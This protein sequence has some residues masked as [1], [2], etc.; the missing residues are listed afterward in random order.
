[1]KRAG[2][3]IRVSHLKEDG[4][5]PD[6]QLEKAQ[7]QADL[8]DLEIVKVYPDLDISGRSVDKRTGFKSM[9]DDVKAGKLD[10][11]LVYRLDRFARNVK[12]FHAYMDLLDQNNCSLV[13]ISQN[14]DTSS[15]TGRLLRNIL[16]DFA[17][18][19]SEMISERVRDNMIQNARRGSWNGGKVSFGYEWDDSKKIL[20]P[21]DNA[22]WVVFMFEEYAKGVGANRIR[23]QL[24]INNITSPTGEEWW[25][26]TSIR[27]ILKNPIY[28]GYIE[29]A[30]ESHVGQHEPI[31]TKVLYER[32]QKILKDN[33]EMSPRTRSSQHLLSGLLICPFCGKHLSVRYNGKKRVRRYVC[34]T[35]SNIGVHACECMIIDADSLEH[36][37]TQL[38]LSLG[39][40]KIVFEEARKAIHEAAASS[41]NDIA[42]SE[43]KQKQVQ[44]KRIQQAMKDLFHDFYV[45]KE[46]SKE[47]FTMINEGLLNEE[48]ELKSYLDR[49]NQAMTIRK[50]NE[51]NLLLII[52]QLS[53]LKYH[54]P[55]FNDSEK[56]LSL[57]NFIK[58]IIPYENYVQV[59]L[60]FSKMK[61][62]PALQSE[63]TMIF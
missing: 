24:K 10:C 23:N 9:M 8:M 57:R 35:R 31:I 20:I 43:I 39:D 42:P 44:L 38:I 18:F 61:I 19:E 3:Y 36:A 34:Y 53:S 60:F 21:N 12:D 16:I 49:V 27:N 50:T 48:K 28:L 5:S 59:D 2:V 37:I 56:R 7:L 17:Q 13:S 52:D 29:Y 33:A 14:L 63:T 46:I 26:T 51:D 41:I 47:Q 25:A 4:V 55:S 15:P 62:V 40:D 1:M 6:T 45:K 30:G 32:V 22:R 54:W 58:H 11:I